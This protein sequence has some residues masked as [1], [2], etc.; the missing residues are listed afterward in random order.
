[1]SS[2]KRRRTGKDFIDLSI[3]DSG[4]G[5]GAGA[6]SGITGHTII[7]YLHLVLGMVVPWLN[8]FKDVVN[9]RL[10]CKDWKE[11]VTKLPCAHLIAYLKFDEDVVSWRKCFP[12]AV[13]VRLG[14][15]VTDA[16]FVHL[17]GIQTLDMSGCSQITDAGL[18]HLS[19]IHTLNMS[20][21]EQITD[22]GLVH[23]A[24]IHTLNMSG[25]PG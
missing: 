19:G 4:A 24:G 7:R 10:V 22:A 14:K 12:R 8:N 20:E 17:A 11:E 5:A 23:L 6:G 13:T 25:P 3:D 15:R 18:V 2:F 1:M 9:M 16:V 21:C